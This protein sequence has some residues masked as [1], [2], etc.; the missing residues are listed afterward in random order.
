M[1]DLIPVLLSGIASGSGYALLALG[2]VVIFRSTDAVNFA[3]GDI[4]A[5]AVFVAA[6]AMSV[7]MPI[8]LALILTV[9]V[10]SILGMLV[11]RCIIRR[12]GHGSGVVFVVLVT[13]IGLGLVIQAAIGAIWGNAPRT[14]PALLPG[15]V[16]MFGVAIAANKI[17]ATGVATVAMLLVAWFFASTYAGIAMRASA[18]DPYAAHL[19]GLNTKRI[20]RLAWVLGCGLA[21]LAMYFIAADSTMSA[22]MAQQPLFR[23]FA[24][25]FLGGLTSM[26]GAVVGGF[27]IG[28]LD[29][30]AGRYI[31]PN[32]RDTAVFSVIVIILLLRPAGLLGL[33]RSERV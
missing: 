18:E 4:G 23:A 19:L 25:V 21:G 33:A 8:F 6:T 3:I 12:L 1:A 15:S 27:F 32:F 31:S 28:V 9:I 14:F 7:G 5:L 26:P 24:G 17:A 11:E 2:V 22:H 16:E 20:A 29:N 10:S 13:T 30:I